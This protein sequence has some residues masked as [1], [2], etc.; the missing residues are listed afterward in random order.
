LKALTDDA[1]DVLATALAM[2]F[3]DKE[4]CC[5]R[6]SALEDRLP[7]TD[8][9]SL[10]EVAEKLQGKQLLSDGRPIL[11]TAE[12]FSPGAINSWQVIDS[13][14][15]KRAPILEWR[16]QVYVVAGA[17]FD[18]TV[19]VDG[20]R[21]FAIRKLLLLDT[22]FSDSRRKMTIACGSDEWNEVQGMLLVKA[23]PQ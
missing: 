21:Q 22:R 3:H 23:S 10:K 12:Y 4:V 5:E 7:Q 17:I 2:S 19:Q 16:S 20:A 14:L 11:V 18:E 8:P 6:S 1:S 9:V 15:G 13:I